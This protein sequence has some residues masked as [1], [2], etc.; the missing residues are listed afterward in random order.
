MAHYERDTVVINLTKTKGAGSLA[1]EW[2]HALDNYFAGLRGINQ[3]DKESFVTYQPEA[4]YVHKRSNAKIAKKDF[5]KAMKGEKFNGGYVITGARNPSDWTL[6]DGIRPE[7]ETAFANLVEA[8][9]KAP[10]HERAKVLDQGSSK[11]YWSSII[12]RAARSFEDYTIMK[13]DEEGITNDYLANVVSF[14]EF[15]RAKE[16]YPYNK[17]EEMQPIKEAFDV[18]FNTIESR[19]DADGNVA[20]YSR[21]KQGM[22]KEAVE[23]I[24]N[25]L[26]RGKDNRVHIVQSYGDLPRDVRAAIERDGTSEGDF[27]AVY[28]KGKSYIVADA[29]TSQAAVEA[30]IFHEHFTHGGLRAKYG[31]GLAPKLD[32]MLFKSGGIVGVRMQAK[33]QGIDLSAYERALADNPNISAENKKR[34]LMEELMAHMA[35][36]T[37]TLRRRLEEVMGAIRQWLRDNGFAELAKLRTSDIAYVLKQARE[38][39]IEAINGQQ[40][41][42]QVMF[43]VQARRGRYNKNQLDL[44]EELNDLEGVD[45]YENTTQRQNTTEKQRQLGRSAISDLFRWLQNSSRTRN[46]NAKGTEGGV[47]L[48]GAS[49]YKNFKAGKPYQLL[50][51][52]VNS[53]ADLAAL[54]QV[55][56][57]PR[58]ETFRAFYLDKNNKIILEEA[59]STRMPASVAFAEGTL[60]G[61]KEKQE[62]VGASKVYILHNHPSGNPEPSRPDV[63]LTNALNN[64]LGH[65]FAGHVVIDHNKYAFINKQGDYTIHDAEELAGIDYSSKPEVPHELLG[66]AIQ[67]Q[68]DIAVIGKKLAHSNDPVIVVTKGGLISRTG[69]IASIPME[70]LE[71][72]NSRS[73]I[74]KRRR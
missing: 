57:D 27:N 30:A 43:S 22:D 41:Q 6:V 24:A 13:L 12:E 9:N 69:L 17:P 74:E 58:F 66:W 62:K 29:M 71:R 50:G 73:T 56:R 20:L 52:T 19:E 59:A 51:K 44:F 48:I 61:I 21:N 10:M 23:N 49:I 46:D 16:R 65:A 38:A 70:L 5:E 2:F 31:K 36:T 3:S 18:L 37:G 68:S 28:Y 35:H 1:H 7:V 8:L 34:I 53:T 47:S 32:D 54:A 64:I 55:Y 14:K 67:G 63:S 4:Y 25:R 15:K 42:A 45:P 26:L 11:K 33:K 40:A 72:L 60:E 39:A